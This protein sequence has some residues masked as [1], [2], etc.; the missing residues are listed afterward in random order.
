MDERIKKVTRTY[1]TINNTIIRK[2]E[3]SARPKIG[4]FKVILRPMLMFG[5]ESWILSTKTQATKKE[6]EINLSDENS[7]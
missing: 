2:R 6:F 3:I 4:V 7:K 1:H 5:S